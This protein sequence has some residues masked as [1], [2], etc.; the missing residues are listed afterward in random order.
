VLNQMIQ[1]LATERSQTTVDAALKRLDEATVVAMTLSGFALDGMT[2]DLGWRFLSLGRRIERYLY[3]C[4][5]LSKALSLQQAGAN[6]DWLLE[7]G[8][9]IATYRARY[10]ASAQW[11]LLLDLLVMDETNPRSIAFQLEGMIQATRKLAALDSGR[12]LTT[13]EPLMK[14]LQA[15]QR[16]GLLRKDSAKLMDWLVRAGA[17]GYRLSDDLCNRFFSYSGPEMRAV[18]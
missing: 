12:A 11:P 4:T 2:R 17:A 6:L 15:L 7:I 5:V 8:D 18:A 10:V 1:R 3:M 16:A 9:S 13:L 14:E